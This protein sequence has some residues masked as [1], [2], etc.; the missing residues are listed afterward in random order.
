MPTGTQK[1]IDSLGVNFYRE[2]HPR[3]YCR[4][5]SPA[6]RRPAPLLL[7]LLVMSA[8][9]PSSGQLTARQLASLLASQWAGQRGDRALGPS[10]LLASS[11]LI[12]TPKLEITSPTVPKDGKQRRRHKQRA[13]CLGT[14]VLCDSFSIGILHLTYM[15]R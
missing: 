7:L 5:M 3:T 13:K 8:A 14:G 12:V 9:R 10:Q 15:S 11:Q 2:R 1:G 6:R 4:Q